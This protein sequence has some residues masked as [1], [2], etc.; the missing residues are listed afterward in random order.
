MKPAVSVSKITPPRLPQVLHRRRLIKR[1]EKNKGKRLVLMLGQ[2]AQGKS[3]LAASYLA[4][5]KTPCAWVNLTKDDSDPANLYYSIVHA[6]Q[7]VMKDRD[8]SE[9]LSYPSVSMGPREETPL[10]REWTQAVFEHIS[11]SIQIV[12]DALDRLSPDASSLKLLQVMV[13]EAPPHIH[14]F[15]LSRE[16]PFIEIEELKIKQE[17]LVLNNEDL[18]FSLDEVK[19]F[20]R[21]IKGISIPSRALRRIHQVTEGWAGGLI[22]LSETLEGLPDDL[23]EKYVLEDMPDPFE[24]ETFQYFGEQILSSQ[25][26]AIQD[27]LM[28]SSILDIVEPGFL[29]DFI[30]TEGTTEVLHEHVRKNLFV[31][32]TYDERKGWVFR[33][34]PLFKGFLRAKFRSE[35]VEEERRALYFKAGFLYEQRAEL[36]EAVNFYLEAK[37]YDRAA[38]IIERIG[39]AFLKMGRTGDLD[40]WLRALPAELVQENPWL[41]FYLA[42]VTRFTRVQENI[43]NLQRAFSLFSDQGNLRGQFL[44]QAF[45]IEGLIIR[46]HDPIPI[47]LLL[48]Q[49]EML[50]QP[51]NTDLFPYE[52]ALLWCQLGFGLTVRGGNPRRGFWA[53]QNAYLIAKQ[54]GDLPLQVNS[55]VNAVQ[56]LNWLGEFALADEKS[57]ELEKLVQKHPSPGVRQ[58]YHT[59]RCESAL[60]RGDLEQAREL[61]QLAQSEAER[62]GLTYLHPITLIYDLLLRP[63]LGQYREAEEIGKRL[64]SFADSMDN[65]LNNGLALLYL[66]RSFY[67]EGEYRK[68]QDFVEKSFQLLSSDEARSEY[69]LYLI[70]VLGGF[71][72]CHLQVG[73][74]AEENLQEALN[75]FT[76][77]SSFVAADAHFAMAL[78]KRSQAKTEKAAAHLEAGLK[79]GREKGLGHFTFTSPPDLLKICMLSLEL[80]VQGV[81]EYAAYLLS[82]CLASLAQDELGLLALHPS[83]KIREKAAEIR[84]KIHRSRVPRLRIETL[85][86]FRV[87]RGDT[88]IEEKEWQ[89]SQPKSLLKAIASHGSKNVHKDLLIEDLWTEGNP[90]AGEKN[91]KVTLHRLRKA[92]EPAMDQSFGSSYIHLKDNFLYLDEDLCDI[93]VNRFLSLINEGQAKEK[94][95]DVSGALSLYAEAMEIYTGEFL[96]EELYAP[97]AELRKEELRRTYMDL[98]FKAAQLHESRGALKKAISCYKKAIHTDPLL[99]DAYQRLMVLY[100]QQGRHNEAIKVYEQCRRVL[101]DGLDAEPDHITTALHKRIVKNQQD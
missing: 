61:I 94:D 6:L 35:I 85:G 57:K 32:S 83:S 89:G 49:A 27:F 44:S 65:W 43:Q 64:V 7:R 84:R 71:I 59:A 97:W 3:T 12:L 42:M 58:L 26:A 18:A 100:S 19:A 41:L 13:S 80:E 66:G 88:P 28:K 39:I 51:S 81:I 90:L 75:H 1:L 54:L 77:L 76:D 96:P 14:L 69:H 67:F 23:R 37:A 55:L 47:G 86:G 4:T 56:A 70:Y 93:D 82:T 62:H 98:L 22:L 74:R 87:L 99:E 48:E 45:L 52:R 8:L 50:L 29:M 21:E 95:G 31:Q 92:L 40:N 101:R 38:S 34:H 16:V 30:E 25:P 36:E 73:G 68:A 72:S 9:L 78:L 46:G 53:C 20:F 5:S 24:R 10:Y 33:Y 63:H 91:F 60:F 11:A 2:A 17:A 79:I 15:L